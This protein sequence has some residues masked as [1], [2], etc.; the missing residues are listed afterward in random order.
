VTYE[1]QT[2]SLKEQVVSQAAADDEGGMKMKK[3]F[4]KELSQ[5]RLE[6]ERAQYDNQRLRE[7]ME[8]HQREGGSTDE[9]SGGGE[10]K[11][12]EALLNFK[13]SLEM[14]SIRAENE[15]LKEKV[16]GEEI[17]NVNYIQ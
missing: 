9:R 2:A 5:L 6:L 10:G 17:K 4:D 14:D 1:K 13:A 3:R 12:D 15:R 8:C 16:G 7:A 11:R